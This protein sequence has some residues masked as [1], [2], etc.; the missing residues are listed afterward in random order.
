VTE[1]GISNT[2]VSPDY[3]SDDLTTA[4]S[5][6]ISSVIDHSIPVNT[7][8]NPIACFYYQDLNLSKDVRAKSVSMILLAIVFIL[9]LTTIRRINGIMYFGSFALAG[10]EIILILILQ[11]TVGNMYQVT[12]L[13]L[14]G[15]MTGL[16]TGAGFDIPLAGRTRI[17]LKALILILLYLFA[18]FFLKGLVSAGNSF[19]VVFIIVLS[20]FFPSLMTGSIFRQ[21]TSDQ[22]NTSLSSVVYSADLSGAAAGFLLFSGIIIPVL[23]IG[24][25]L[26]LIP[27]LIFTGFIF[28]I[29]SK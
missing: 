8:F 11:I 5:D 9:T 12:G 15:M 26:F 1:K 27:V 18:A 2:Y 21:L 4:K 19:Q 23:G 24:L 20:G 13:I 14:A 7:Y 25:S 28:I 16:A 29:I 17:G 10:Y 6:E 3:L 22:T